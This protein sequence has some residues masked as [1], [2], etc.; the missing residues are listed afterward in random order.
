LSSILDIDKNGTISY[1]DIS[2]V[3]PNIGTQQ[4][5]IATAVNPLADLT[6][7]QVWELDALGNFESLTNNDG[8][9]VS[10]P[11]TCRIRSQELA[12]PLDFDANGNMTVDEQGRTFI[13]DAWN[14]LVEVKQGSTTLVEYQYDGLKRR[15]VEDDG[16]DERHLYYSDQWQ[17]LEERVDGD[18]VTQYVWSAVYVDAMILR[19]RDADANTGNGLEER[20]Y[21]LHDANYNVTALV[22]T[23]GEVRAI[24]LRSLRPGS[25]SG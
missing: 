14:R 21:V 24:L 3:T 10:L 2:A 7:S 19:D 20:I 1:A 6:R 23:S 11:T 5:N 8:T 17:V 22:D 4:E 25:L 16:T 13:W 15:I 9:P 18:T 12:E